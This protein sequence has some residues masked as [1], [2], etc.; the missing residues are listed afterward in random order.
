MAA[1]TSLE[2]VFNLKNLPKRLT[3]NVQIVGYLTA[4]K[5]KI[6]DANQ[7]NMYYLDISSAEH[8]MLKYFEIG[9]FVKVINPKVG[10]ESTLLLDKNTIIVNGTKIKDLQLASPYTDIS[11]TYDLNPRNKVPGKLIG[12]VVKINDPHQFQT[13]YGARNKHS[14]VI[15]DANGD[16]QTVDSWR[17]CDEKCPVELGNVYVFSQMKTGSFPYTKP[18]YLI[19]DRDNNIALAPYDQQKAMENVEFADGRFAGKILGINSTKLYSNCNHC[20]SHIYD[21]S[22]KVGEKCPK[23]SEEVNSLVDDYSFTLVIENGATDDIFVTCYK[24]FLSVEIPWKDQEALEDK[25][26]QEFEGKQ[27][28]GEYVKKRF[29]DEVKFNVETITVTQGKQHKTS[30]QAK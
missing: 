9:K 30:S 16:K 29:P 27:V 25:L 22:F 1:T 2:K 3:V 14:F 4:K 26:C 7:D 18:H 5:L 8:Y 19:N 24:K 12:K 15:K 23:C 13:M 11:S 20:K 17:K 10:Q 6:C 28:K 21:T